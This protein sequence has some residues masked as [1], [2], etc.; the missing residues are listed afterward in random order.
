MGSLRFSARICSINDRMSLISAPTSLLNDRVLLIN[1]PTD[2]ME[3]NSLKPYKKS[4]QIHSG[5]MDLILRGLRPQIFGRVETRFR[6]SLQSLCDLS[7]NQ[8]C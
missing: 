6:L 7:N 1:A 3:T 5:R 4:D 8:M 2:V